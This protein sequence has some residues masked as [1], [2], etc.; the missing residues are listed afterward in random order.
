MG[1]WFA[2]L[3]IAEIFVLIVIAFSPFT[4]VS[5]GASACRSDGIQRFYS[6]R[7]KHHTETQ[8][9]GSSADLLFLVYG[10]RVR[11]LGA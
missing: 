11:N 10:R 6:G 2:W 3:D 1:D 8:R 5:S 7:A 9:Y 4:E